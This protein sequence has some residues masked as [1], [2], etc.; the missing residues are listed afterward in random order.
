MSCISSHNLASPSI[1]SHWSD[2]NASWDQEIEIIK[3]FI[4]GNNKD[5]VLKEVA[6]IFNNGSD[7]DQKIRSVQDILLLKV[8]Q[9]EISICKGRYTNNGVFGQFLSDVSSAFYGNGILCEKDRVVDQIVKH[10]LPRSALQ[11]YKN[12]DLLDKQ[13]ELFSVFETAE[14]FD[15][16][17]TFTPEK[18]NDNNQPICEKLLIKENFKLLFKIY[19]QRYPVQAEQAASL[20][21]EE[22]Q[23]AARQGIKRNDPNS[24]EY[25]WEELRDDMGVFSKDEEG[26][27][28]ELESII[29]NPN[30]FSNEFA[31]KRIP[32]YDWVLSCVIREKMNLD[33]LDDLTRFNGPLTQ[34]RNVAK[35]VSKTFAPINNAIGNPEASDSCLLGPG[36]E[37]SAL[38][39]LEVSPEISFSRYSGAFETI[40]SLNQWLERLRGGLE[41]LNK[42]AED[43]GDHS[44]QDKLKTRNRVIDTLQQLKDQ[45]AALLEV[46]SASNCS[47]SE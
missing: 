1:I 25:F 31:S 14:S 32:I 26:L 38:A 24:L 6:E 35:A 9:K 22:L 30:H 20:L 12:V 16:A 2:V 18:F 46:G 7:R 27:L 47:P 39:L 21:S 3:K 37:R 11:M 8:L 5:G 34:A 23:P 19:Y 36:Y 15:E 10:T 33:C 40:Q 13:S 43:S 42:E 17:I 41:M 44:L 45:R 28:K 29:T 4:D